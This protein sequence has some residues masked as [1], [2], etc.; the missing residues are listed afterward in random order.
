MPGKE[1]EQSQLCHLLHSPCP[2]DV[3]KSQLHVV[4]TTGWD[5]QVEG[6]QVFLTPMVEPFGFAE[7]WAWPGGWVG[8]KSHRVPPPQ[9]WGW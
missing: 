6:S 9:G 5:H 4:G 2:L 8:R 1:G 7:G 3:V